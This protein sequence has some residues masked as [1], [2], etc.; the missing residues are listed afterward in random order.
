MVSD[1]RRLFW[2][3]LAGCS[4][5]GNST[6]VEPAD[7]GIPFCPGEPLSSEVQC[8]AR[9]LPVTDGPEQPCRAGFPH[10]YEVGT[11]RGYV[12]VLSTPGDGWTGCYYDPISGTLVGVQVSSGNNYYCNGITPQLEASDVLRR[13]SCYE[14]DAAAP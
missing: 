7:A 5:S 13:V 9:Y 8:P 10:S 4:S 11:I 14:P 1:M 6:P 3:L 2:L 12:S